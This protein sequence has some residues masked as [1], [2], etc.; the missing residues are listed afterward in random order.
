[1]R[2]FFYL[3]AFVVSFSTYAQ[4]EYTVL[5]DDEMVIVSYQILEVKKKG[6]LIPEIRLSIHNKSEQIVQ[7]SFELNLRYDMEFAEGTEVT[8]ICIG[9]GKTKKGKTKGL[10]YNPESLTLS[11][12]ESE[13]FELY[14]DELK[15]VSVAKCK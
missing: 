4:D 12:L 7:V 15:V 10:F 11:Q 2:I 8:R 5:V 1:M 3:I 13:D 6:A 14:L 9:A